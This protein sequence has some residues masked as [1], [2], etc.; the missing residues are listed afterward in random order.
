[1]YIPPGVYGF[2]VRFMFVFYSSLGVFETFHPT[3]TSGTS[4]TSDHTL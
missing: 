3:G 1:V 4:G 2:L